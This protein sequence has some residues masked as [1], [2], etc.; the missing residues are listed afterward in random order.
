MT[1]WIASVAAS[2]LLSACGSTT[3][4]SAGEAPD[5]ATFPMVHEALLP[6]CGTLDC[7][8]RRERNLRFY[9]ASGRRLDPGGVPGVDETTEAELDATYRS[10]VGLEPEILRAV[11]HDHGRAPERLTLVRKA[12]GTEHH[13]PGPLLRAGDAADRC[14]ISWLA[15][16][17]DEAA[18]AEAADDEA[19][20]APAEDDAP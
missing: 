2:A 19:P 5:R 18:C 3:D 7:H 12:R 1:R 6:R 16:A 13:R 9:G 11:V 14:L 20:P 17:V 4:D 10:M 15:S 8:G